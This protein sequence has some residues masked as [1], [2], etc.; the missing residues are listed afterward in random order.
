VMSLRRGPTLVTDTIER[1][2]TD[3]KRKLIEGSE[4]EVELSSKK[5]RWALQDEE[6]QQPEGAEAGFQPRLSP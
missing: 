3:V 5:G 2:G 4:V 1:R 6:I